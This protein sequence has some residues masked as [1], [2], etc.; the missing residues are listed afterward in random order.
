MTIFL[1]CCNQKTK[2]SLEIYNLSPILKHSTGWLIIIKGIRY[3]QTLINNYELFLSL[4]FHF[5]NTINI[6]RVSSKVHLE[7]K[8]IK[9]RANYPKDKFKNKSSWR[10][11]MSLWEKYWLN[12]FNIMKKGRI[13]LNRI[14][15]LWEEI[16]IQK[17]ISEH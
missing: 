15:N 8:L 5:H 9:L 1:L 6:C 2:L 12:L 3:K 17:I 14:K 10:I 11:I 16:R 13:C 7:R 4:N